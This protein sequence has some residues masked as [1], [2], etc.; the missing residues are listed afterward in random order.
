MM[1]IAADKNIFSFFEKYG[2][3]EMAG[4]LILARKSIVWFPDT[5]EIIT[6]CKYHETFKCIARAFLIASMSFR[7]PI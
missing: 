4:N 2:M 1:M 3:K 5:F 6:A 7:V